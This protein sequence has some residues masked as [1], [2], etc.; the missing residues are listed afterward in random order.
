MS[1]YKTWIKNWTSTKLS[2]NTSEHS[3][4]SQ[5]KFQCHSIF[6]FL[7]YLGAYSTQKNLW[8][9]SFIKRER[10][11]EQAPNF[12]EILLNIQRN[13]SQNFNVIVFF[14]LELFRCLLNQKNLW[15]CSFIKRERTIE[16]APN[17]QKILLN[18]QKSLS[19]NFNVIASFI[20]ELLSFIVCVYKYKFYNLYALLR[21]FIKTERT[22]AKPPNFREVIAST[23][24]T[25]KQSFH[26]LGSLVLELLSSINGNTNINFIILCSF[27]DF[28]KNWTNNWKNT[29][30]WVSHNQYLNNLHQKFHWLRLLGSWVIK[31]YRVYI[32]IN[33]IYLL[34]HGSIPHEVQQ[35][36]HPNFVCLFQLNLATL[37]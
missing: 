16:Q 29:K 37:S 28:N 27:A 30:L 1:F 22:I 8:R 12:Q 18:I 34:F 25:Y 14:V 21:S 3:E 15:R 35:L 23:W 32:Y 31:H 11:F 2:G 36:G 10:T 5:S 7:S 6:S 17:F 4:K 24:T 9:C 20:L 26:D 33:I 19:Q 13:L